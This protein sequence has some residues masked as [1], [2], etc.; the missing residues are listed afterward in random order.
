MNKDLIKKNLSD[1]FDIIKDNWTI[2]SD[3]ITLSIAEILEYDS[4]MAMDMWLYIHDKNKSLL[5]GRRCSILYRQS[6][7][8]LL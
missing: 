6:I 1:S 5:N 8:P 4:G 3:A 7:E 2:Y